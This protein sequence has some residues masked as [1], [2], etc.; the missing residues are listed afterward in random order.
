MRLCSLLSFP[1][2]PGVTNTLFSGVGIGGPRCV[3]KW[4]TAYK[5]AWTNNPLRDT[6]SNTL[7][8]IHTHNTLTQSYTGVSLNKKR[9]I[10]FPHTFPDLSRSVLSI[11]LTPSSCNLIALLRL[12]FYKCRVGF[13]FLS[14]YLFLSILNSVCSSRPPF[15]SC[16]SPSLLSPPTLLPPRSRIL[17]QNWPQVPGTKHWAGHSVQGS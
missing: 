17:P 15:S 8:H 16:G 2:A 5:L 9:E 12:S 11:I 6:Q 10:N 3:Q 7:T 1:G 14:Y 4:T 13:F